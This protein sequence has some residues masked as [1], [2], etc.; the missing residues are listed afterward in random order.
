MHW[1]TWAHFTLSRARRRPPGAAARANQGISNQ[2]H[3]V[4]RVRNT[5]HTG[6]RCRSRVGRYDPNAERCERKRGKCLWPG[7][8]EAHFLIPRGVIQEQVGGWLPAWHG[9]SA[10]SPGGCKRQVTSQTIHSPAKH[11][12][13]LFLQNRNWNNGTRRRVSS[14]LRY[15]QV[16]ITSDYCYGNGRNARRKRKAP[17]FADAAPLVGD[18]FNTSPAKINLHHRQREMTI[19]RVALARSHT[20]THTVAIEMEAGSATGANTRRRVGEQARDDNN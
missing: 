4:S 13:T 19:Q 11:T 2:L 9:N 16:L 3:K 1:Q 15:P 17:L 5:R 7:E 20:H 18:L 10:T 8:C 12:R 6:V 14:P